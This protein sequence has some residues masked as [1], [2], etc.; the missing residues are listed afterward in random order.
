MNKRWDVHI[1]AEKM[2]VCRMRTDE[3]GTRAVVDARNEDQ[4][5]GEAMRISNKEMW[6]ANK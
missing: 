2:S 6:T 5:I 3:K 1:E 4:N